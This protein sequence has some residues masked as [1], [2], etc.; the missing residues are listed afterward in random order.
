MEFGAMV[1][2]RRSVVPAVSVREVRSSVIDV[3]SV[4]VTEYVPKPCSG[5]SIVAGLFLAWP[6]HR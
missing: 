1:G 3:G 4:F 6:L 2:S 5:D